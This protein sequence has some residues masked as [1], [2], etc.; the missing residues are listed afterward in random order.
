MYGDNNFG[1]D[2]GL[3]MLIRSEKYHDL[4]EMDHTQNYTYRNI[5]G[6]RVGVAAGL[7]VFQRRYDYIGKN[8][9]NWNAMAFAEYRFNELH[10]VRGQAELLTSTGNVYTGYTDKYTNTLGKPTTTSREGVWKYRRKMLLASLNY[11]VSLTNLCSGRLRDRRFELE[12]FAGPAVGV[13][14]STN[15]SINPAE[16]MA[17]GDH[18]LTASYKDNKKPMVGLDLGLKLSTHIWKGISVFLTPTVY[19]LHSKEDIRGL[20]TVSLGNFHLY[21]T[22]NV[23]VQYKIGKLRRNP[24]VVRRIHQRQDRDWKHKQL[25]Q[26]QKYAEKLAEKQA[27]RKAKYF[28]K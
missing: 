12:A 6:T 26:E 25:V 16:P 19:M 14:L 1:I 27:K 9:P 28:S 5:R 20:N 22:L 13:I 17:D 23:G 3:T 4:Y 21:Q 7:P 8:A 11:E 10:S 24:E 18:I 2:F 15:A